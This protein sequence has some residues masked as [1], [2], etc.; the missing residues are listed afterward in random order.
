MC[1]LVSPLILIMLLQNKR[2]VHV[3]HDSHPTLDIIISTVYSYFRMYSTQNQVKSVCV[4]LK[5]VRVVNGDEGQVNKIAMA[6]GSW[7]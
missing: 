4:V 2:Q 1:L 3:E 7:I 6:D 5:E